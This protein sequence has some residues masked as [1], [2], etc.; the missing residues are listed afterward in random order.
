M[1]HSSCSAANWEQTQTRCF[2][3]VMGHQMQRVCENTHSQYDQNLTSV[4]KDYVRVQ[5]STWDFRMRS[6]TWEVELWEQLRVFVGRIQKQVMQVTRGCCFRSF[7]FFLFDKL[8][9]V[10]EVRLWKQHRSVVWRTVKGS[11]K[12]W[13]LFKEHPL[14][15][16]SL[17]IISGVVGDKAGKR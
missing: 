2:H 15:T 7:C 5:I 9:V 4:P 14:G 11:R 13:D 17:N 1:L 10:C 8:Q 6:G 12:Q 16:C 3:E